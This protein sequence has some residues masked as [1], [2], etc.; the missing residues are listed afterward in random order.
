MHFSCDNIQFLVHRE[1][2]N[3]EP[4]LHVVV[5]DV[6][7]IGSGEERDEGALLKLIVKDGHVTFAGWTHGK[8]RSRIT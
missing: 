1:I 6:E 7:S 4:I 2:A 5:S 8:A 3:D